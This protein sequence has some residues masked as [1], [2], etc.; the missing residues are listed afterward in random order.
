MIKV[1]VYGTLKKGLGL[2]CYMN[3][4]RFLGVGKI[5][6]F[7]MFDIGVPY[8]IGG[9]GEIWGEVYAFHSEYLLKG[10]DEL[11]TFYKRKFVNVELVNGKIVKDVWVYVGD[12]KR[13]KLL[14]MKVK[15]GIW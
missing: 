2:S 3:G 5:K 1:F 10:L 13:F 6:G 9:K 11:E 14:G 12:I 15:G 4:C 7:D 8:I